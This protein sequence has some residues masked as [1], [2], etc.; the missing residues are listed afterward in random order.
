MAG[1]SSAPDASPR[2]GST[3]DG[4]LCAALVLATVTALSGCGTDSAGSPGA[5]DQ[6]VKGVVKLPLLASGR[7]FTD[8]MTARIV[9]NLVVEGGCLRVGNAPAVWPRGTTWDASTKT[10][11]LPSGTTLA[12]GSSVRAGGGYLHGAPLADMVG[13]PVRAAAAACAGA[14]TDVAVLNANPEPSAA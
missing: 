13:D 11:R 2:L 7:D 12:L 10:V 8:A 14:D 5:A 3:R 9:G 1:R 4:R 6:E